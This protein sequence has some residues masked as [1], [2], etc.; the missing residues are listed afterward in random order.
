MIKE[1]P[2]KVKEDRLGLWDLVVPF[3]GQCLVFCQTKA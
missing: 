3:P 1:E 2:A